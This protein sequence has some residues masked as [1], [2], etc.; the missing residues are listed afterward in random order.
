MQQVPYYLLIGSGRIARHFQHYFSLIHLPFEAWCRQYP[1]EILYQHLENATH[2]LLLISDAA[3]QDFIDTHLNTVNA[4]IIH[5]SG[6]ILSKKAYGAHPLM[7]FMNNLYDLK[8]Y[9]SLPFIIDHDAPAFAKLLPGLPNQHVR[10]HASLKAK[11]HALC[12][13]SGNFSCM[14][15]QKLLTSFESE[16]NFSKEIAFPYLMQQAQNLTTDSKNALTGPLVRNDAVT[17]A[18]NLQALKDD[19]FLDI[20]QSFITCYQQVKGELI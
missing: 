5:F 19:P 16:L 1:I 18:K 14:L 4:T 7:S 15:W 10:I 13:L 8:T 6:S 20:Y 12:V 11:Y 3:I 17:I 2:I 9:Q